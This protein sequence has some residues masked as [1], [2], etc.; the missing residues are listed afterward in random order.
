[1]NTA[2]FI[3]RLN[4][5][6]SDARLYKLSSPISFTAWEIDDNDNDI[7]IEISTNYVVVS[8]VVALFSG[9]ETFIFPSDKDGNTL[10]M[11][12]LPG[13]SRGHLNH[14]KALNDAGYSVD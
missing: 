6:K 14:I 11:L 13:S 8:A 1:M 3:K 10:D 5:W 7:E 4:E 12:E 2:T 9:P